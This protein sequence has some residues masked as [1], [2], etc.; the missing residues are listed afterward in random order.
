MTC[1]FLDLCN[2]VSPD[3]LSRFFL[4]YFYLFVYCFVSVA[5]VFPSLVINIKIVVIAGANLSSS[6]VFVEQTGKQAGQAD[7]LID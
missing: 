6:R 7:R 2:K 4:Y 1:T 5:V 3:Y